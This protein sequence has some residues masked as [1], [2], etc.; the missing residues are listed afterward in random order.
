[1]SREL[2]IKADELNKQYRR[3]MSKYNSAIKGIE[4]CRDELARIKKEIDSG[5]ITSDVKKE[6]LIEKKEQIEKRLENRQREL[7][8]VA[9]KYDDGDDKRDTAERYLKEAEQLKKKVVEV[10]NR[11]I[12]ADYATKKDLPSSY[13]KA[14]RKLYQTIIKVIDENL[15]ED[16]AKLLRNKIIEELTKP[17]NKKN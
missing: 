5:G 4:S 13:S 17:K 1:M 16:T 9:Q 6:Q 7:E 14:E 8:K 12:N 3:Q 2:A 15:D 11:I 10:E